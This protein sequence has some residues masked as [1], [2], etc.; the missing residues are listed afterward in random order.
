MYSRISRPIPAAPQSLSQYR[1]GVL[2]VTPVCGLEDKQKQEQQGGT[3]GLRSKCGLGGWG[4]TGGG[5]GGLPQ[6]M[7]CNCGL[8]HAEKG[9]S[10]MAF[11]G[12]CW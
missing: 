12:G 4:Q 3:F 7:V 8:V 2:R 1:S 6:H 11:R 10:V 5:W 9:G